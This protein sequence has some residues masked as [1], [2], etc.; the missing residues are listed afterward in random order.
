MRYRTRSSDDFWPLVAIDQFA[1]APL[2]LRVNTLKIKREAA[3]AELAKEGITATCRRPI[4]PLGLRLEGKPQPAPA[5]SSSPAVMWR[6]KTKAASC[7]RCWWTRGAARWWSTFCA[8]AGGK[9]LALGVAMRNTGRLYAFDTSGH[10]L[11]AH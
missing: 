10:R 5:G 8:G 9:T 4:R 6:Y 2:D 11:A 7:S 1:A 3:I